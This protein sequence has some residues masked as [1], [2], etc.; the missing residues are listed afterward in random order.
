MTN[1][2]YSQAAPL[3]PLVTFI[4]LYRKSEVDEAV[5]ALRKLYLEVGYQIIEYFRSLSSNGAAS[6]PQA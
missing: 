6:V 1:P 4:Q 3:Q 5:R 2:F